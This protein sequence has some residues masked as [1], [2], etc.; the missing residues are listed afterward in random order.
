MNE[1]LIF[2]FA[3]FDRILLGRDFSIVQKTAAAGF[4]GIFPAMLDLFG[5]QAQFFFLLPPPLVARNRRNASRT[6]V[7]FNRNKQKR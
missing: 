1:S 2:I 5:A 3:G 4:Q 6:P 7:K